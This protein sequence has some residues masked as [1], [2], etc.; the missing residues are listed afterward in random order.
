MRQVFLLVVVT[1]GAIVVLIAARSAVE[2]GRTIILPS[3]RWWECSARP[4]R[5]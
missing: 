4:A 3:A 5:Q 2:Q 1:V